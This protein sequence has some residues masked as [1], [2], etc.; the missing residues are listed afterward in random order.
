MSEVGADAPVEPME[1]PSTQDIHPGVTLRRAREACELSQQ[2]L[3]TRLR[4]DLRVIT[5]IDNGQ[6]E[7]LP[8]PAYVKG[9]LRAYAREVG[10]DPAPILEAYHRFGESTP[11]LQPE[12][13]RPLPELTGSDRV[14][15]AAS[16]L[17]VTVLILLTGLW[18]RDH[19][20][21][22]RGFFL[23]REEAVVEQPE[24]AVPETPP[25]EEL[26]P[27]PE[28]PQETGEPPAYQRLDDQVV[29]Y[30][31]STGEE[32]A[33]EEPQMAPALPSPEGAPAGTAPEGPAAG[34][35]PVSETA[36]AAMEAA[37]ETVPESPSGGAAGATP[38][39]VLELGDKS[40]IEIT[41]ADG[42]R[43]YYNLGKPG[44]TIRVSGTPPY[45][46][47]IGNS[48]KVT[49]SVDGR[50]L[51]LAPY[52]VQGVARLLLQADGTA[53]ENR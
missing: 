18:V 23:D 36:P 22:I 5:A 34:E 31:P 32:T 38:E 25:L 16:Y 21:E 11:E 53:T 12:V 30:Y 27:L 24:V 2:E 9:Y 39:L 45:T 17:V 47:L 42:R 1:D 46:I 6:F 7:R 49:A 4:L 41:D 51:D 8:T 44:E 26:P 40:W 14:V 37:T 13:S 20:D 35:P 29:H 15:R 43:L 10:L 28:I 48:G 3:A 50:P 52:S 19:F 33:V